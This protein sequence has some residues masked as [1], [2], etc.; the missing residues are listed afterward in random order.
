MQNRPAANGA[1]CE[2]TDLARPVAQQDT[3]AA[4]DIQYQLVATVRKSNREEFRVAIRQFT[5]YRGVEL[6]VFTRDGRGLLV[7]SPRGVAMRLTALRA[8]IEAL[9][10]AETIAKS[11]GLR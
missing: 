9:E 8:V 6:R 10:Q 7:Q 1:A 11:G 5:N 3:F 2:R 4:T